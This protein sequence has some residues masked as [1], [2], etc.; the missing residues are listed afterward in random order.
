MNTIYG[1]KFFVKNDFLKSE[2]AFSPADFSSFPF[3]FH[4]KVVYSSHGWKARGILKDLF[5]P[6]HC[7][8]LLKQYLENYKKVL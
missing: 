2:W 7:L 5:Y 4:K 8:L 3:S 6:L 1:S